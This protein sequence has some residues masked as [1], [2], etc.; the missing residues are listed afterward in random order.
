VWVHVGKL[1]GKSV[2][3]AWLARLE[4]VG[5]DGNGR[6]WTG[7]DGNGREWMGID[8]DGVRVWVW[9]GVKCYEFGI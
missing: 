8:G 7:M 9:N 6:E 5:M 3:S 2:K 1:C 4:R